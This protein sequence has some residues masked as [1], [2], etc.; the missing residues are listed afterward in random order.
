MQVKPIMLYACEVWGGFGVKQNKRLHLLN[1]LL[2]NDK[3][4]F[5][6]LNIKLCK[7]SLRLPNRVSN[8]GCR[9]ELGRIP[10]M[11]SIIVAILKYY[12]RSE[13]LN[14]SDPL[15][16]AFMSQKS[17]T[18]NSYNTL[19]FTDLCSQRLTVFG[20]RG[21]GRGRG[22]GRERGRGHQSDNICSLP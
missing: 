15:K 7:R 18:T 2:G 9:A 20:G 13:F 4:P 5:E 3:Y 12:I 1:R 10:I 14:E 11:K 16:E 6:L 22:R 21:P 19:T 8:M 17:L